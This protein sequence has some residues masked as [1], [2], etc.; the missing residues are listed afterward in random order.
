MAN[1]YGIDEALP[2]T[3]SPA[4]EP[5]WDDPLRPL[6]VAENSL[7]VLG[8]TLRVPAPGPDAL[9][10]EA[11]YVLKMGPAEQ[12]YWVYQPLPLTRDGDL[13]PTNNS[14]TPTAGMFYALSDGTLRFVLPE[15]DPQGNPY[16]P[17]VLPGPIAA[18][19]EV[20]YAWVDAAGRQHWM[21]GE[22]LICAPV[23]ALTGVWTAGPVSGVTVG[24]GGIV[25]D[26]VR[27]TFRSPFD[28]QNYTGAPVPAA[29][30]PIVAVDSAF[31][32]ALWFN[33][34]EQ[35]K[36]VCVGYRLRT[37]ANPTDPTDPDI[38]RRPP[39]IMER[40]RVPDEPV[41]PA[42]GTYEVAL[43]HRKLEDEIP[44]FMVDRLG[45]PLPA[46][47]DQMHIKAV[48]PETG[49]SYIDADGTLTVEYLAE[50]SPESGWD[51]GR[52]S[53]PP[54]SPAAG[55]DL[56]FYYRTLDRNQVQLQRAPASFVENI[57]R[58]AGALPAG[59]AVGRWYYPTRDGVAYDPTS[60]QLLL[61]DCCLTQT[62][63]VEYMGRGG[64]TVELHTLGPQSPAML[65]VNDPN[66]FGPTPT[67]Q[68]IAVSGV[69]V[70][71]F[72]TWFD[73]AR[74]RTTSVEALL[75]AELEPTLARDFR[76]TVSQP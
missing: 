55:R 19:M 64:R 38:G 67:A 40:H 44:L 32:H 26:S 45:G 48:D 72:G 76:Q 42:I 30:P 6:N 35:G 16:T 17:A 9:A 5:D 56:I 4:D 69:S 47:Y 46:P 29:S 15:R 68:I 31:G 61:P 73:R 58:A 23:G 13:D 50:G 57:W 20:S 66:T 70:R 37:H 41:D 53:F 71:S 28:V 54:L 7:I 22:H 52:V 60:P 24:G 36:T 39:L 65:T 18:A 74:L 1:L 12:V 14:L 8:E 51:E 62:V 63:R 34:A 59:W 27:A 49:D 3:L 2:P 33:A 10:A 75:T 25:A 11:P 21:E 43:D